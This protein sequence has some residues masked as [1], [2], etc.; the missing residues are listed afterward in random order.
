M[1]KP[2]GFSKLI[3]ATKFFLVFLTI[4]V[5]FVNF[6]YATSYDWCHAGK[7]MQKNHG[8]NSNCKWCKD[9]T[10]AEMDDYN[11]SK[12]YLWC[13]GSGDNN[14]IWANGQ[15]FLQ[16]IRD[17]REKNV[18][19]EVHYK[20]N[21]DDDYKTCIEST[22]HRSCAQNQYYVYIETKLKRVVWDKKQNKK[23]V[24]E[25]SVGSDGCLYCDSLPDNMICDDSK[26]S[27]FQP[28]TV[29]GQKLGVIECLGDSKADE[30]HMECVDDKSSAYVPPVKLDLPKYE[31][32]PTV[33]DIPR[34]DF[35]IDTED[36]YDTSD[37][38][39][40]EY[41]EQCNAGYVAYNG[42]CVECTYNEEWARYARSKRMYCPGG[43]YA[44]SSVSVTSQ[45]SKCPRMMEPSL[46]LSECECIWGT[47]NPDFNVCENINLTEEDLK[48]GPAGCNAPLYK[49][50]WTKKKTKLYLKCMGFVD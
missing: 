43:E 28:L 19:S 42:K 40:Y 48:C 15:D 25:Y 29:S 14:E 21:P 13:P 10:D 17:C 20:A 9:L 34:F 41:V 36:E 45:M 39:T 30:T 22:K 12:D 1:S 3:C 38:E 7:Y 16:G 18:G 46:D 4:S 2:M 26:R 35:S 47:K 8:N 23:V 49:Q 50:C 6:G 27:Q 5:C 44:N 33:T 24:E 11:T 37:T 31:L 32:K